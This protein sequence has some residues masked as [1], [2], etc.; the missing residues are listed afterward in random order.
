MGILLF[1]IIGGILFFAVNKNATRKINNLNNSMETGI[2]KMEAYTAK[3]Q[4]KL[5]L[6]NAEKA[7]KKP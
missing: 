4:E 6:K 2:K 1:I 5:N 7:A 3:L